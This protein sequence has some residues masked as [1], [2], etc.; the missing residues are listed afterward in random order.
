MALTVGGSS[1]HSFTAPPYSQ[2]QVEGFSVFQIPGVE[3]KALNG[4]LR[5]RAHFWA[6]E[7]LALTLAGGLLPREVE[8]QSRERRHGNW[9]TSGALKRSRC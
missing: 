7:E 3:S 1:C 5:R 8:K 4:S 9:K 6:S 2:E